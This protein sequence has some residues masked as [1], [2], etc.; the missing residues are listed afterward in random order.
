MGA[1]GVLRRG[2]FGLD[3]AHAEHGQRGFDPGPP[4]T[5]QR[6]DRIAKCVVHGYNLGLEVGCPDRLAFLLDLIEPEMRGFAYE[7]GAMGLAAVDLWSMRSDRFDRYVAGPAAPHTYMS[8]I[9]AGGAAAVFGRSWRSRMARLDPFL[10]WLVLDGVGFFHAFMKTDRTVG[11]R[12]L[13]ASITEDAVGPYHAGIGRSLW[14]IEAGDSAQLASTIAT[15][16]AEVHGELWA[17]VGLAA[18]YAGGVDAAALRALATAAGGHEIQLARG[19]VLAA[20]TRHVAANPAPHVALGTEVLCGCS[21]LEAHQLA[22]RTMADLEDHATIDG[23]PTWHTWL[24]RL[25]HHF[26]GGAAQ[27]RATEA[28]G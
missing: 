18:T 11:R 9:G 3:L 23:R 15:F 4:R 26:D 28:S 5:R 17:G 14:F 2:L 27:A 7:G 22:V 1:M 24:A 10:S 6:L 8:Y 16:A 25:D 12:V 13:P 20:H 19:A 21:D